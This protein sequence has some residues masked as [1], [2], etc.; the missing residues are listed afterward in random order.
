MK[1]TSLITILMLIAVT[2]LIFTS[3]ISFTPKGKNIGLQLYSLRD[4]IKNDVPGTIAKVNK[5]GYKF[6]EPAGYSD[7]KFYGVMHI[8]DSKIRINKMNLFE[9]IVYQYH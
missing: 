1:K 3:L 2:W 9:K 8:L 5:M 4:S 6:V 7:G